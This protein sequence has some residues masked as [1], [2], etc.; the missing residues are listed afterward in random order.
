MDEAITAI[1]L[2]SAKYASAFGF[3]PQRGRANF[4]KD[5]HRAGSLSGA[6]ELRAAVRW[7][8]WRAIGGIFVELVA[9]RPN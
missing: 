9:Q 2:R 7:R 1:H 3:P 8:N 4:V 5:R 6:P